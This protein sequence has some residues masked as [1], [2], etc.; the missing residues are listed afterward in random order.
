L[1][2]AR[3]PAFWDHAAME[4]ASR[5]R[6]EHWLNASGI[7]SGAITDVHQLSGGTQNLL[8]RITIGGADFVL[9]RPALHARPEAEET[10]RREA[11][12]LASLAATPVPHPRFRGHCTDATV[13]GAAFLITDAVEGFNAAVGLGETALASPGVRRRMGLAMVEGIAALAAVDPIAVGLEGFGKLDTFIERQVPRWQNQLDSYAQFADW[14]GP[15]GLDGI[16]A[17]GEW[18]DA[19]RPEHWQRGLMHGDFHIGNVLFGPAGDLTAILDWELSTLGDPLLDLGRLLAAW[20]DP[21]GSGPLSLK[22]QPWDAFPVRE[23]LI[24]HYAACTGRAM[25]DLV[26]FEVLAC[27]KLA[28]ILEGTHARASAGLAD[29]DVGERLHR[30]AVALIGRARRT[31]EREG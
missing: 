31:L 21:D 12:V 18:L 28:I 20:P 19:H 16:S 27:Y 23:E 7:A 14:P 22:V 11:Q 24:S 5:S 26:W 25:D 17:L 2:V 1:C 4:D 10:I 15:G 13:I 30:G 8:Y 6:L 9:R 29:R 3:L